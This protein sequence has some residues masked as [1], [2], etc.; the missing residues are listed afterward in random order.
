MTLKNIL[1]LI[2]LLAAFGIFAWTARRIVRYLQVGKPDNR[3]DNFPKRIDN[4]LTIG[5]G[6]SKILADPVAGPLHAGIFW[7]FLVLLFS[8]VE[9]IGEGL[10]PGFSLSFLGPLYPPIAFV[11]DIFGIIVLCAVVFALLR[12]Y[13]F[14]PSR[15]KEIPSS[16][17]LD[18][19]LILLTIAF[20]MI[21]MFFQNGTRIALGE[22]MDFAENWRPISLI[23]AGW[24]PQSAGTE[25]VFEI[26]WWIH[27]VLVLGFLNFLPYSKHFHV[28]TS[29][30]NVY[31][32]NKGIKKEADGALRALDLEDEDAEKFGASDIEDLTWKQLFDSYTC[33]ECGRCT[34]ACPANITGKILSPKKII[35]D[36]RARFEE[37]APIL[38]D[39]KENP[40]PERQLMHDF[41]STEELWAC[42]TCRACVQECPVMIEHVDQIV[43]MRRELV[44]TEGEFPEELQMLYR[45]LENNFAPWQFSPEDR[46]KWADG[47]NVQ[48]LSEL[49]SADEVDYLFWVGCAGSFDDRYKKVTVAFTKILQE[50]GISFAILGEEEKCNGDHARRSGNEYLAQMLVMENVETLNNYNVKK[51]VTA[52]PHC[53][54]SIANEFPQFGGDYEVI[55]HSQLID[56]LIDRG[57]IKLTEESRRKVTY[58]D[59]CYMGRYNDSYDEP[60][61]SLMTVPGM[62]V[63]E[64]PRNKEKGLCCG[65][66]GGRMFMEETVGK[67][68]NIERTEEALDTGAETVAA[69]CPFC[70]TMLTDG[71]KEK[72]RLEEVDVKDIAEIVYEAMRIS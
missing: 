55:H 59:S 43:E 61:N 68:V 21:S 71:V 31:F 27:I 65:A 60:R 40:T 56:D 46:A 32:S 23:V 26:A 39:G 41:I 51:I 69:E 6:Q 42:T 58:H 37:K 53:F 24:F 15:V 12:R 7:G 19:T 10:M 63:V 16:S 45:N 2:V 14:G 48:K 18:A 5:L 3:F 47:L 9:A 62:E 28:I 4:F 49:G 8:V 72:G 35:V 34:A 50:A 33:T 57:I 66:G 22:G 38:A 30:P 29:L 13:V 67:K 1:F 64:M 17:Q 36:T 52:C 25:V 44:L 11:S 70:L 20:I 54:H